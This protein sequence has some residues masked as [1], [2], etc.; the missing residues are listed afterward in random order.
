MPAD[1]GRFWPKTGLT[2]QLHRLA[3]Q[4]LAFRLQAASEIFVAAQAVRDGLQR[5]GLGDDLTFPNLVQLKH[6]IGLRGRLSVALTGVYL[7]AFFECAYLSELLLFIGN[8]GS[9]QSGTKQEG[10]ARGQTSSLF[11]AREFL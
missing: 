10:F 2:I 4:L 5:H 7:I 11:D 8:G 9:N 1:S 3:E 6:R